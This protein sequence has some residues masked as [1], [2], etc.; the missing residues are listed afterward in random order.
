METKPS[1]DFVNDP[2]ICGQKKILLPQYRN[3]VEEKTI[4]NKFIIPPL[5][6]NSELDPTLSAPN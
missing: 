4:H 3:I 1:T 6:A 5:F 2:K